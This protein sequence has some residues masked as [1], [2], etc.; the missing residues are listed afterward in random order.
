MNMN[1]PREK[2]K[3]NFLN[4]V[5][6]Y[7]EAKKNAK[8]KKQLRELSEAFEIKKKHFKERMDALNSFK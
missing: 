3:E 8:N 2:T 7:E 4:T 5:K 6:Y 1:N